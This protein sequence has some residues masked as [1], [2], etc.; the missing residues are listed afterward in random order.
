MIVPQFKSKNVYNFFKKICMM[1]VSNFF[2]FI[3]LFLKNTVLLIYK[4]EHFLNFK[5]QCCY[6]FKAIFSTIGFINILPTMVRVYNQFTH[7]TVLTHAIEF[8]FRQFY[9][10]H[11]TPFI[12]QLL[13]C[14]ANY[15][16]I[17]NN[18]SNKSNNFYCVSYFHK[19][20][21]I[22]TYFNL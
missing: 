7:N 5:L 8:T 6:Q 10:M 16:A 22:F 15:I 9:I 3:Y 20:V 4:Y 17:E 18:I 19:N 2:I 12:L 11:R 21:Y 13:G 14:V 1:Y